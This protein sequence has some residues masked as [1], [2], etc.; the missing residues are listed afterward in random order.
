MM[1]MFG[2]FSPAFF[3]EYHKRRPMSKPVGECDMHQ[4]LYE[5]FR[6]VCTILPYNLII[7]LDVDTFCIPAESHLHLWGG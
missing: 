5:I 4:T 6:C 1:R 7:S 2:G 3:E